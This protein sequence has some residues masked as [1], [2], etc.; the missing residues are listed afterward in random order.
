[1]WI[2]WLNNIVDTRKKQICSAIL[3]ALTPEDHAR[4]ATMTPHEFDQSPTGWRE[5]AHTGTPEGFQDAYGAIRKRMRARDTKGYSKSNLLWHAAQMAAFAGDERKA[6]RIM[7]RKSIQD[8][9]SPEWN[10]YVAGSRAFLGGNRI[11]L[12]RAAVNTLRQPT[13]SPNTRIIMGL[14][15]G[16][17]RGKSYAQA[18]GG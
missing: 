15:R 18:Y 1:M 3:E 5:K 13:G 6:E 14:L 9:L 16:F 8:P 11:G 4:Y 10:N 2:I 17:G 12:Q 7:G